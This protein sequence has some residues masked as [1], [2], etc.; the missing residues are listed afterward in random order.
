VPLSI[1]R[2]WAEADGPVR[3][4]RVLDGVVPECAR[5][6]FAAAIEPRSGQQ[7]PA[8]SVGRPHPT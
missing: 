6:T 7:V 2:A 5:V 4:K 3:S 1:Y 8:L